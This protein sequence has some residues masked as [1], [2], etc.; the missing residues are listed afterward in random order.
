MGWRRGFRRIWGKKVG[1]GVSA[2]RLLPARWLPASCSARSKNVLPV[3]LFMN[4]PSPNRTAGAFCSPFFEYGWAFQFLPL[5]SLTHTAIKERAIF[6]R[7]SLM[8]QC[9]AASPP[10]PK[11]SLGKVLIQTLQKLFWTSEPQDFDIFGGNLVLI[12]AE[13]SL[14]SQNKRMPTIWR[15]LTLLH[16][17]PGCSWALGPARCD[18]GRLGTERG[19]NSGAGHLFL[20]GLILCF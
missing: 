2:K 9:L 18:F 1:K 20:I 17:Q 11:L 10:S 4:Y 3:S 6:C 5:R 12:W 7:I 14:C 15:S 19:P 13:T 8:M 16:H